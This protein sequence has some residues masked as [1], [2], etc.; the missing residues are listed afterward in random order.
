MRSTARFV[1]VTVSIFCSLI[2]SSAAAQ[3]PESLPRSGNVLAVP[4]DPNMSVKEGA[5]GPLSG[6]VSGPA[7]GSVSLPAS[8]SLNFTDQFTLSSTQSSVLLG[9]APSTGISAGENASPDKSCLTA[10][11]Y[12]RPDIANKNLH[13]NWISAKN[14]CGRYIKIKVCYYGTASCIPINVP[15][16]QTKS[17]IIG[18]APTAKPMHYRIS[19]EN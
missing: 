11:A 14:G 19:L 13:Q 3:V 1:V 8:G 16:W 18:Y 9:N 12:I 17:A 2:A 4:S 6:S 7:I 10:R 15:P 5:A